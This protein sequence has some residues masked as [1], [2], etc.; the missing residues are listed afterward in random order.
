MES[1]LLKT[2]LYALFSATLIG[3]A[4]FG[5]G[6]EIQRAKDVSFKAPNGWEKTDKAESDHAF[7]TKYASIATLTSSCNRN[8]DAPLEVL[9]RHLLIGERNYR[10]TKKRTVAVGG[11]DGLLSQVEIP[12][13]KGKGNLN[14]LLFVVSKDECIFDFSLISPK[15]ISEPEEQEFVS[16]IQSLR[17]GTN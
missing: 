15:A 4:M 7:K 14:L 1:T 2:S 16:F 5:G 9:T 12:R 6:S 3:C 13:G 8:P 10:I 17:Y 11:K